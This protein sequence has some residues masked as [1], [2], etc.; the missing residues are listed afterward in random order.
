M[1]HTFLFCSILVLISGFTGFWI[2][3]QDESMTIQ[4][5]DATIRQSG[6]T[7]TNPLLECENNTSLAKQ[8][9]IPF[10]QDSIERIEREVEKT[11]SG[12]EISVYFRNLN[13]GPWFGINE[14]TR[15]LP[16]SLMKTTLLISYLKWWEDDPTLFEKKLKVGSEVWLNQL[17]PPEK[18]LEI[19]KEYTIYE[20]LEYLIAY[21]DNTASR[22]L[23]EYIPSERQNKTFIDLG[24]PLPEI[25]NPGYTL[26]VKEYASF[27]RVLYNASYLSRKSSEEGLAILAKSA[28]KD[29]LVAP[30]PS[31]IQVAHKFW[32]REILT[33]DGTT[34][35]QLHDCGIIY[36]KDY[37]YLLCVMT[38]AKDT[39]IWDLSLIIRDVSKIIF[40]EIDKRYTK[41]K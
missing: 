34:I 20:L 11:H 22:V 30:L 35:N 9:Y 3:N 41:E 15:F 23:F 12:T 7:F 17:I 29:G 38:R 32:E 27:F 19:G 28:F 26:T 37:P 14:N 39:S 40:E 36:D 5:E 24:V 25:N 31:G 6:Y 4:T 1:K 33:Q 2:W 21:S 13:N 18:K 8:K 16:A 10:E